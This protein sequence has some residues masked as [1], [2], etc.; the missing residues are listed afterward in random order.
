MKIDYINAKGVL[1]DPNTIQYRYKDEAKYPL[2]T[3]K[4][5]NIVLAVGSRPNLRYTGA[6][7]DTASEYWIT[8]DDLFTLEEEPGKT[9]VVLSGK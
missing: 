4:A 2:L 7:G 5:K 9:L 1:V 8:S 3:V 6:G